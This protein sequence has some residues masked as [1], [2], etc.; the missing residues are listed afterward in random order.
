MVS[1][2]TSTMTPLSWRTRGAWRRNAAVR[3]VSWPPA[4]ATISKGMA[5]PRP[6]ATVRNTA[7]HPT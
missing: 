7:V 2:M 5:T 3:C 6:K 1:A 4:T